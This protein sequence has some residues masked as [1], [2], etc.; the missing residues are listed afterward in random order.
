M[1]GQSGKITLRQK[2]IKIKKKEKFLVSLVFT[3]KRYV[4]AVKES[5]GMDF[6][7]TFNRLPIPL[8][9]CQSSLHQ[10]L[11]LVSVSVIREN[12]FF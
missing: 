12:F 9:E 7:L 2:K 6:L 5:V 4:N 8:F 3:M 10:D 1:A 11:N